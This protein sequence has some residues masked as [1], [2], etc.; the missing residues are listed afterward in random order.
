MIDFEKQFENIESKFKNI[1]SNLNSQS[2]LEIEKLVKLNK[3][4]AELTPIVEA[5]KRYKNDKSEMS[6]LS[7]LLDDSDPLGSIKVLPF[8]CNCK[9]NPVFEFVV[10]F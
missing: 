7:T 8:P 1:E 10:L 2:G 3:E 5:I 9:S 6:E 4:Y